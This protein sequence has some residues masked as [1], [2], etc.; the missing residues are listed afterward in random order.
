VPERPAELAS[1]ACVVVFWSAGAGVVLFVLLAAFS[2]FLFASVLRR[3]STAP[4]I[5]P[6][7]HRPVSS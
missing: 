3:F 7:A 4:C 2:A 6:D 5:S 1:V